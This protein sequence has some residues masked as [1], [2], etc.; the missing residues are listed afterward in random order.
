MALFVPHEAL[1]RSLCV[2]IAEE[3]IEEDVLDDFPG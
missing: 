1:D 2:L 3:N